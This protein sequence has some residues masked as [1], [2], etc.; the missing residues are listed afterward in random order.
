MSGY[1][2]AP[3]DKKIPL[4]TANN[5]YSANAAR[6]GVLNVFKGGKDPTGG[7][8]FRDGTYFLAWGLHS[9]YKNGAPHAKFRQYK[10]ITIS[11]E[12][13]NNYLNAQLSK[14]RK[15]SVKYYG[16]LY[17]IPD[18]VFINSNLNGFYYKSNSKLNLGIIATG[19]VGESIFWKT[20]K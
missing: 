8:T 7:A 17:L 20:V 19:I 2:S 4:S 9:Q 18:E 13:F 14:Y 16:E 12:I 15:G 11:K 1:S 5:N 3:V 6:S 10:S